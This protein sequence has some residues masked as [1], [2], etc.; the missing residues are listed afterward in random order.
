MNWEIV[1][2][3]WQDYAGNIKTRWNKLT[4]DHLALID[5]KRVKLAGKIQEAYGF[6]DNEV[7]QELKFFE[8]TIDQIL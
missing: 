4:E 2:E 8:R 1:E 7:E 3:N 6:T 5:G